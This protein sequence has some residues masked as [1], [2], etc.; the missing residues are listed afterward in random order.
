LKQIKEQM[1]D[2]ILTRVYNIKFNVGMRAI[3][4]AAKA[5]DFKTSHG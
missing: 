1:L 3:K 4:N 2:Q 5:K